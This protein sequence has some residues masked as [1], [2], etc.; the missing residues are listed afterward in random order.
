MRTIGLLVVREQVLLLA[1][2]GILPLLCLHVECPDKALV[3]VLAACTNSLS[4][5]SYE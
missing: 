2:S 1:F 3:I 5:A 4:L